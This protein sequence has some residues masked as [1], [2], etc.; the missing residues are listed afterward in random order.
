MRQKLWKLINEINTNKV[1]WVSSDFIEINLVEI[2]N[3]LNQNIL[4]WGNINSTLLQAYINI[5]TALG[6]PICYAPV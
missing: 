3:K 5:T 6:K 4:E 2:N 1:Y